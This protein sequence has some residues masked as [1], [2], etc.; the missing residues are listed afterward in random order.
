VKWRGLGVKSPTPKAKGY[1]K[2]ME[3]FRFGGHAQKMNIKI[4]KIISSFIVEEKTK[5]PSLLIS[6]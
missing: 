2:T 4:Y 5:Q 6:L 1:Q 3:A